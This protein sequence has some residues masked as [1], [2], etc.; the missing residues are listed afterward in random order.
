MS[1]PFDLTGK[2][3]AVTGAWIR[4]KT[5][6]DVAKASVTFQYA[7]KDD[8][9]NDRNALFMGLSKAGDATSQGAFLLTR[10]ANLRT[11]AVL[12]ADA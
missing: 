12:A 7:A 10:G 4:A 1:N 2:V 8:R 11:L 3:A 6:R 5:D 9:G